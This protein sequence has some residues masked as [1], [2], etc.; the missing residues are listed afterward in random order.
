MHISD[1]AVILFSV[2]SV[3][4]APNQKGPQLFRPLTS[5]TV[6]NFCLTYQASQQ[7]DSIDLSCSAEEPAVQFLRRCAT[8]LDTVAPFKLSEACPTSAK[9]LNDRF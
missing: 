5:Q 4:K 9:P 7:L 8:T 2:P 3:H 1:H 6:E